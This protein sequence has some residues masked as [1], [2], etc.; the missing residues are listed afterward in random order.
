M[1][2]LIYFYVGFFPLIYQC[3]G[4]I[5]S[6]SS[7][8][9][10]VVVQLLGLVLLFATRWTAACQD[11]LSLTVFQYL[12]KLTS[13]DSV[14]L[15]NH[16]IWFSDAI[17]PSHLTSSSVV[18][19][20]SCLQPLPESWSFPMSPFFAASGVSASTSILL[21]YIQIWLPLGLTGLI[22]LP[23]RDP[24]EFFATSQFKSINSSL[25]SF[26]YGPTHIYTWLLEKP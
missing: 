18:H 20:S 16:P 12:L 2:S 4:I 5:C 23:P 8:I 17:K 25:L 7:L 15:S 21:M 14:M 13:I 9:L 11:S 1:L 19:F 10:F 6:V 26:L 24:W 22:A 3:V